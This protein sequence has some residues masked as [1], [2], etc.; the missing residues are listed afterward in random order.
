MNMQDLE[1]GACF[2]FPGGRAIFRVLEKDATFQGLNSKKTYY[3]S[4]FPEPVISES[5][6]ERL[7]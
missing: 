7:V 4:R 6:M 2:R 1:S 5:W 3:Q